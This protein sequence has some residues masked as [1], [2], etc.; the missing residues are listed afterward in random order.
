M[1]SQRDEQVKI[2]PSDMGN[3]CARCIAFKMAGTPIPDRETLF[4]WNGTSMHLHLEHRIEA[5]QR[6]LEITQGIAYAKQFFEG[7][8]TEVRV[9]I[10]EIPG[11]GMIDGSIDL[12]TKTLVVD[13]KS[14]SVAK[15]NKWKAELAK[16]KVPDGLQ[17]HVSQVTMYIGAARR[18]GYN[19]ETGVLA[20]LPRDATTPDDYW[21]YPVRY[22]EAN[23]QQTVARVTNIWQWVKAGRHAEIA[24]DPGCW[25]CY[26]KYIP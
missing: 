24:A 22:S 12:L 9:P 16:G 19:V 10:C 2:G 11:Y 3:P 25:T 23:E 5:I 4:G 18:L 15:L 8:L 13:W 26:P 20:F 14:I 1:P 17:K 6:R 21:T 7:A